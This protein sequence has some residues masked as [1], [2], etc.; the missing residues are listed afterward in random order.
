MRSCRWLLLAVLLTAG[1]MADPGEQPFATERDPPAA[2]A[3]PPASAD[4]TG[5]VAGSLP[6]PPPPAPPPPTLLDLASD[7]QVPVVDRTL[8]RGMAEPRAALLRL[9]VQAMRDEPHFGERPLCLENSDGVAPQLMGDLSLR[10]ES[11][12]GWVDGVRVV[13]RSTGETAMFVHARV[14]CESGTLCTGEGGR[15]MG[16]MG[17]ESSGYRLRRTRDGWIVEHLGIQVMS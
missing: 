9:V 17:H 7:P 2:V 13:L 1:C 4:A 12:C 15:T 5:S 14:R 6:E 8:M 11:E 10:R 3:A 16:N